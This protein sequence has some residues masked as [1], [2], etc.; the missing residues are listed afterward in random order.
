MMMHKDDRRLLG[1]LRQVG[2]QPGQLRRLKA[3][4]R[5]TR[6]ERVERDEVIQLEEE[7]TTHEV[8]F[9]EVEQRGYDRPALDPKRIH[10]LAFLIRPE[11]TPYDVWLDDVRFVEH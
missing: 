11:D 7:W 3:T 6:H 4:T 10:S 1:M 2:P 9:D 5:L 8:R